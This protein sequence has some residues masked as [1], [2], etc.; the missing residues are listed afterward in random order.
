MAVTGLFLIFFL[1]FH[2]YGNLKMF[3]GQEVY[4]EYAHWLKVDAFVPIFPH[5]GFIWVFRAIVLAALAL[6]I[7]SA[8]TLWLRAN[9]ATESRYAVTTRLE[10]TYS[11]R[12]MRWGGVILAGFLLWHLYQ[13][14]LAPTNESPYAAVSEAFSQWYFVAL[15]ALWLIAVC[16]H[17]RHGFW[18][19]FTTLGANTSAKAKLVLDGLAWIVAIAIYF[20]FILMP[21]AVLLGWIG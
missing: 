9:K 17:V 13:F 7:W 4:D 16:M 1:L 11:S 14:T 8:I 15:Y 19:A 20:G 2:M 3:L 12:M 18:S 6:H 10:Q 5:G 21:V